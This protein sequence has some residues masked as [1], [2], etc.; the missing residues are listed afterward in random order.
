[1]EA[2]EIILMPHR[3]LFP[4]TSRT[5]NRC[6]MTRLIIKLITNSQHPEVGVVSRVG[7]VDRVG[8]VGRICVKN[9]CRLEHLLHGVWY[10]LGRLIKR[11]QL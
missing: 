1:M 6:G 2:R 11:G 5:L 3:I 9:C 4:P 10:G 8:M 7:V